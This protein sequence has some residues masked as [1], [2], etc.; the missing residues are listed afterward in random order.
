[1]TN[2]YRSD[3]EIRRLVESFE[4]CSFHPSEFRHYQHLAVALWYVRHLTPDDALTRMTGGIR[5]LAEVYGKSGYHETITLFWLLMVEDF[6]AKAEGGAPLAPLANQLIAC[7]DNKNLILD[8][9][10]AELLE[11]AQA[12][13]GWV[14]PDLKKLEFK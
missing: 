11:S 2:Y 8:Y 14:E 4:A 9:Y 5:R 13:V 12:K 10:S 7:C 3:D 1:M 6:A